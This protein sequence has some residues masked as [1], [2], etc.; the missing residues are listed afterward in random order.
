M[1]CIGCI[2]FNLIWFPDVVDN[3]T[4]HYLNN[5]EIIPAFGIEAGMIEKPY[6]VYYVVNGTCVLSKCE[7]LDMNVTAADFPELLEKVG[8]NKYKIK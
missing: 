3:T 8:P 6:R 5:A 1:I 7:G 4:N 2:T